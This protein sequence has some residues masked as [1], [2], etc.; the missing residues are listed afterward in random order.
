MVMVSFQDAPD[1]IF[2]MRKKWNF[3]L[4]YKFKSMSLEG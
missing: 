1:K 3:V 2:N 4:D